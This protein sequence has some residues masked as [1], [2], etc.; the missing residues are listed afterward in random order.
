MELSYPELLEQENKIKLLE[1]FKG[2]KAHHKMKCLVCGH[3]WEAT[4]ISKRQTYKKRGVSGCPE[5]NKNRRDESHA[6]SR[7][8]NLQFL[9]ERGIIVLTPGYD[10]RR[11][12]SGDGKY[13]KIKVKNTNC[14]HTWECSPTNLLVNDVECGVCGPSKR[15]EQT[16]TRMSKE[17]SEK[18]R[19]TATDWEVYKSKVVSLTEYNYNQNIDII[20]PNRF[21]RGKAGEAGAYHLDHIVPKRF[22]FENNIPPHICAHVKNLQM[23][24]WEENVANRNHLKGTIPPIFFGYIQSGTKL[25]IYASQI[26]EWFNEAELFV[27][28]ANVIVTAYFRQ[29]N[30][31]IVILP[32]DQ[33]QAN[34]KTAS[35]TAK[36]LSAAGIKY[37]IIFED[38]LTNLNL[39]KAKLNHYLG[40]S[41]ATRI[42]ARD[43]TIQECNI[44]EKR[45]LLDNNHTQGSDTCHVAYGA[46]YNDELV[47]VMTFS[48]PRVALGQGKRPI[49]SGTWELSRFCT[50]VQYKIPGIASKLL[51]HFKKHHAWTEIYSYAD[52][53]WSTG[54]MYLA[55]GFTL[56]KDNPPDYSYVV[57]GKRKHR[58]NYRKDAIKNTMLNYD[59]EKTEYEN[60]TAA[61]YWRVWD[62][63]TLKFSMRNY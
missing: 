60:M 7:Q 23:V 1:P 38:E 22:C 17:R 53:R 61:G 39:I 30:R 42:H 36:A 21:Q 56:V 2:A 51:S 11:H 44:L 46:Y 63:G 27:E 25:E 50:D 33:S 4:P 59:P 16:L 20:N 40:K 49:Q 26:K 15:M 62:C 34:I 29:A 35:T 32:I 52:K 57:N 58:W 8:D 5:C 13:E 14:G 43:C 19:E 9:K 45:A 18:W 41:S 31:A 28:I 12:L 3:K 6:N 37:T 55:L 24:P 48:K 10:G 47:A 54:D